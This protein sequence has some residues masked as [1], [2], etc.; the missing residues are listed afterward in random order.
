[1]SPTGTRQHA[2][3]AVGALEGLSWVPGEGDHRVATSSAA[4]VLLFAAVALMALQRRRRSA[5]GVDRQGNGSE[6][7]ET[8]GDESTTSDETLD[9]RRPE[10]SK[11]AG[12]HFM[13]RRET[14][15]VA[16]LSLAAVVVWADHLWHRRYL[17][18]REGRRAASEGGYT[19]T[20]LSPDERLRH[21]GRLEGYTHEIATA[22][23]AA[24]R[25]FDQG[26]VL[27]YNFNQRE[28]NISFGIA[29][30]H[31]PACA[32]CYWGLAYASGPFLNKVVAT[33]DVPHY[34]AYGPS[35]HLVAQTAAQRALELANEALQAS[36]DSAAARRDLRYITA[37]QLRFGPGAEPGGGYL[38]A[39]AAY[40]VAMED[41]ASDDPQDVDALVLAAES[42]LNTVPWDYYTD[43]HGS[44]K[45]VAAHAAG[46]L[47]RALLRSPKHPLALHLMVHLKEQLPAGRGRG[48]AGEAELAADKLNTAQ[49]G[50]GHL[51]HMASHMYMRVGR[52]GDGVRNSMLAIRR[53]AADS[54]HCLVPYGPEHN[55]DTIIMLASMSGEYST[56]LE[57][58]AL[59][60]SY[61]SG[62]MNPMAAFPGM[63]WT[64]MFLLQTRYAMWADVLSAPPP[65]PHARGDS[66]HQGFEFATAMWHFGRLLALAAKV[67]DTSGV[68]LPK[69]DA[70]KV[71]AV[72]AEAEAFRRVSAGVDDR[73]AVSLPS[74]RWK[75]GGQIGLY[76]GGYRYLVREQGGKGMVVRVSWTRMLSLLIMKV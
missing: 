36:P 70:D 45:P 26:L 30:E 75:L 65:P 37:L 48:K 51:I 69:A 20:A 60:R 39:E 59:E 57:Y 41:I 46:L 12:V 68:A 3:F 76:S 23:E 7:D 62:R 74:P 15:V 21:F 32:M 38:E 47:D 66:P 52:Y 19:C 14:A 54:L 6:G 73:E 17:D 5:G 43:R 56:A 24:Q 42:A 53:D 55:T 72:E 58:A 10:R 35:A 13:L 2:V 8:A 16:L 40:A 64:N 33:H 34:P 25:H 67:S 31:D 29:L 49:P 27:F 18:A 1:M 44:I 9:G 50:M 63:Q 28:A 71:A 61:A 11:T 4:A 22:S